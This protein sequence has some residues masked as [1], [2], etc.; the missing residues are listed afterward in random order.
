MDSLLE[1]HEKLSMKAPLSKGLQDVQQTIDMLIK[2]RNSI[3]DNPTSGP[4]TLA[5]L[6]NPI[7]ASFDI[8][9]N[10]LGEFYKGLGLWSKALDKKF[11]GKPLP[12]TDYDALSSQPSLINRAIGMHLLREGQFSVASAFLTEASSRPLQTS[13]SIINARTEHVTAAGVAMDTL[14]SEGLRKQFADMYYILDEMR[15]KKNLLPA[16][17]WARTNS[18]SLEARGSNLE[19]ELGKSQFVWLFTGPCGGDRPNSTECQQA[20]LTYAREEFGNFQG[21]YLREIQQLVGAMA[22]CPNLMESPY[23]HIFHNDEAW[24]NLAMS[25]TREFCSL[26]GLSADSPLYIAST[27]GVIA[28]P[29]LL[30]L[31]TIM[32]EKRTEWTTQHELPVEIPLPPAYQFHSIFVCPVSKEQTTDL[33]PPMMMPCGHV[34]AHE[35]LLRLSKSGRFKCPYCP[36]ESHPRDAKKVFL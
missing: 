20:A 7:K 13:A 9:K 4:I 5:K 31:Q 30:K 36:G 35:S 15:N 27:A 23:R 29:T 22:F 33:N 26:L 1:E 14:S 3:S 6:Q 24:E 17:T 11:K 2:A 21:R 12:T 19:F 28:L 32:K 10:D 34:I 16:T 8:I 25:F 18:I